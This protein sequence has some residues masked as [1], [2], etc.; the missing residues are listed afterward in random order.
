MRKKVKRRLLLVG[1]VVAAILLFV[2]ATFLFLTSR[3]FA[4][5]TRFVAVTG[6]VLK[7]SNET[8]SQL[9][10][11]TVVALTD[12]TNMVKGFTNETG[13]YEIWVKYPQNISAPVMI[14][15]SKENYTDISGLEGWR[16]SLLPHEMGVVNQTGAY[17]VWGYVTFPPVIL[18]KNEE[19]EGG[20]II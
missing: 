13:E 7:V 4:E 12:M 11:V 2:S 10:G 19:S 1:S 8:Q 14:Y 15:V 6:Q 5:V 9:Q 3:K 17:T 18:A 16:Q 20:E